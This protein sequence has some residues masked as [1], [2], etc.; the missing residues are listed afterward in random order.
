MD[1]DLSRYFTAQGFVLDNEIAYLQADQGAVRQAWGCKNAANL[2]SGKTFPAT[3]NNWRYRGRH[4]A[5]V[6]GEPRRPAGSPDQRRS[7]NR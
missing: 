2:A 3:G 4:Y 6:F 7:S 1:K 5:P